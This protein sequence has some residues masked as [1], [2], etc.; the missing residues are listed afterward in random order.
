MKLARAGILEWKDSLEWGPVPAR[1]SLEELGEV[2]SHYWNGKPGEFTRRDAALA[3]FREH[4]EV[5]LC[6]GSTTLCQLALAQLLDWFSRQ[7][8]GGTKLTLVTAYGGVLRPEQFRRTLDERQPILPAQLRLGRQ[9]WEAFRAP[10]PLRL[11]ALLSRDLRALPEMRRAILFMLQEYP[12]AH[13][14]LSRLQRKLVFSAAS[15]G[16]IGAVFVVVTAMATETVG[17]DSLYGMLE[18]LVNAPHPLLSREPGP[19]DFRAAIL[20]VTPLARQILAGKADHVALNG[21]DRWIGGVHLEGP[22]VKWRWDERQQRI[23]T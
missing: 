3:R 19:R 6:F 10:S 17:D 15:L 11:Q 18:E 2:R 13:D 8:L 5:V 22:R 14:G 7:D 23:V 16:A 21:I 1:L 4:K 20:R 12:E 9:V